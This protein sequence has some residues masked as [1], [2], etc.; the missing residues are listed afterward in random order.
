MAKDQR[1]PLSVL[2][3]LALESPSPQ[4]QQQ[5]VNASLGALT[6]RCSSGALPPLGPRSLS[7]SL[8]SNG[9]QRA[10]SHSMNSVSLTGLP[11]PGRAC[12]V[13][14]PS[15]GRQGPFPQSPKQLRHKRRSLFKTS[16]MSRSSSLNDK[17]VRVAAGHR[18][19]TGSCWKLL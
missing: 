6:S 5:H 15:A 12:S 18:L 11:G 16:R 1:S 17:K 7:S 3:I 9:M 8:S 4:Q 14:P 2:D 13:V 19:P 10:L